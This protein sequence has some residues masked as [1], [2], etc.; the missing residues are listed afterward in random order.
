VLLYIRDRGAL[1][2]E[3]RRVLRPG[4]WLA[5][6]DEVERGG[7]MTAAEREARA[8]FGPAVYDTDASHRERLGRAGFAVEAVEDWTPAFVALNDRWCAARERHRAA[9]VA[10]G[11]EAGYEVGQRYFATNRDAAIAGRLGRVAFLA[12]KEG[13]LSRRW[14]QMDAD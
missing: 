13:S 11:D 9:L 4:G 7:G 6:V 8:L 2:A 14:T 10:Q 5:I 12:R 1:I 3:C